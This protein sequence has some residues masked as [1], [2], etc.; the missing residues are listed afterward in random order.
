MASYSEEELDLLMEA[1]AA[2]LMAAV[3]ADR[4]GPIAYFREMMAGGNYLF[5]ARRRYADNALVQALFENKMDDEVHTVEGSHQA[6]LDD[7]SLAN[8][9]L[10]HDSEGREFR[11]FLYGLAERV[12]EASR[13]R[14]F[15]P[16]V[17]DAEEAFLAELRRRLELA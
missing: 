4:T 15:G 13:S 5:E 3:T 2:V 14:W 10:R 16:K 8:S 1:A 9:V 6:L 7:I 12:V 11:I 17:T